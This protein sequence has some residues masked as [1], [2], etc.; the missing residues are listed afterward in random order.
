MAYRF[1]K[2]RDCTD[3]SYIIAGQ[4]PMPIVAYGKIT[5]MVDTPEGKAPATSPIK[6]REIGFGLVLR[7]SNAIVRSLASPSEIYI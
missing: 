6:I 2:E 7:L 3:G 1:V 4:G 5:V